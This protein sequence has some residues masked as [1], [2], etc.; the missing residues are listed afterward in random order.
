MLSQYAARH[1]FVPI[2][3][4]DGCLFENIQ[5]PTGA[6]WAIELQAL[7]AYSSPWLPVDIG[8]ENISHFMSPWGEEIIAKKGDM[9]C[10]TGLEDLPVDIQHPVWRISR[11]EF[12]QI[13]RIKVEK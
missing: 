1:L 11:N 10:T 3:K 6:V 9:I 13:Y 5:N 4:Q 7:L 2:I 12:E 8:N